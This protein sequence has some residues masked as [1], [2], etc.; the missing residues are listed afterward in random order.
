VSLF[1]W[2]L[3]FDLSGMGGPTSSYATTGIAIRVTES[4]KPPHH[5]KVETPFGGVLQ[6]P[7][8]FICGCTDLVSDKL[9]KDL[10]RKLILTFIDIPCYRQA[11][12]LFDIR[13]ENI[14]GCLKCGS[15]I[16]VFC[17]I[18]TH[19][20]ASTSSMPNIIL[21]VRAGFVKYF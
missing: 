3:P 5:Y 1:V 11:C 21:L 15:I 14:I 6:N 10:H 4:H 13:Q 12:F 8:G 20:I 17:R 19:S 7:S 9:L 2:A 18:V 16:A